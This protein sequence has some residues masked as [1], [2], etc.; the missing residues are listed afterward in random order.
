MTGIMPIAGRIDMLKLRYFWKIQHATDKNLA[1]RIYT[2]MR[3][4]L[5][6]GNEGYI[7]EVFNLCCKFGRMDLWHGQCP[8]KVNPL[9]RIRKI[10]EQYHLK[11]DEE[12]AGKVNCMFTKITSFK[13]KMYSFDDKSRQATV[14]LFCQ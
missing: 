8:K 11:K 1:H 14:S 7:H 9:V 6:A 3:K 4:N 10:V 5:L 13:A 2:E 12:A